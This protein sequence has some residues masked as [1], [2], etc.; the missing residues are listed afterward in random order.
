MYKRLLWLPL[1]RK[2]KYKEEAVKR[3]SL[4]GGNCSPE[5]PMLSP[6]SS[7]REAEEEGEE[8][9][10]ARMLQDHQTPRPT[11]TGSFS[12]SCLFPITPLLKEDPESGFRKLSV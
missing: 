3:Q 4:L 12:A 2:R 7:C 11:P 5:K 8:G 6:G 9:A 10:H 1:S